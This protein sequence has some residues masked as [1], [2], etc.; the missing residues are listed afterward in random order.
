MSLLFSLP[1]SPLRRRKGEKSSKYGGR[2]FAKGCRQALGCNLVQTLYRN[3]IGFILPWAFFS[4]MPWVGEQLFKKFI[5]TLDEP[6]FDHPS[7]NP[8]H[9]LYFL[10]LPTSTL[11]GIGLFLFMNRKLPTTNNDA[12][13]SELGCLV[14]W[15]IVTRGTN[16]KALSETVDAC[17]R[18]MKRTPLFPYLIEIVT[19]EG[20]YLDMLEGKGNN[21]LSIIIVPASYQTSQGSLF[22]ARALHYALQAS[23]VPNTAWLVHLDEETQPT[24]S[25]V[26]GIAKMIAE[27]EAREDGRPRVG[28]G[29]ILYHRLMHKHLLLTFADMLRTGD[30]I[31]RFYLQAF[32]GKPLFGMHG[33]FIVVRN[34][35]EKAI[36]FDFGLIG[37]ITEDAYWSLK[38]ME[39]GYKLRWV[40]GYLSEQCNHSIGDFL[41]QRRRWIVGLSLI[42][43]RAPIQL[44]HRA[45][46]LMASSFWVLSPLTYVS[47]IIDMYN[48]V[49]LSEGMVMLKGVVFGYF[50][51]VY[52][53][54][55]SVNLIERKV[56]FLQRMFWYIVQFFSLPISVL[57]EAT[58]IVYALLSPDLGF[59]IVQK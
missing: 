16:Q 1:T 50:T 39:K 54:G 23:S 55:L 14:V 56:P 24:P 29:A 28:Q 5:L 22:K 15:R 49:Q 44:R 34:D 20:A 30:D 4:M 59:H 12:L 32:L 57:L 26:R 37:S 58:A 48:R 9:L 21:D 18:E 3:L 41:K 27:E 51:T 35:V 47:T 36:G 6:D 42:G 40:D 45:A 10:V 17:R 25:G 13:P 2:S 38:F 11:G 33:S 53:L 8:Y 46:L 43:F 31:S 7:F 52:F 19:E